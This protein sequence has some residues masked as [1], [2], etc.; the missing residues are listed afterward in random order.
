MSLRALIARA[1]TLD[2][3]GMSE[4][5]IVQDEE[6]EV[7]VNQ[8]IEGTTYFEIL[9]I[10]N[11]ERTLITDVLYPFFMYRLDHAMRLGRCLLVSCLVH[12]DEK[13]TREEKNAA[14]NKVLAVQK[15]YF[16]YQQKELL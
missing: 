3:H 5:Y 6:Y 16:P 14:T 15:A 10:T 8:R 12:Q 9:S 13:A 1:E 2:P 7:R 11:D 4:R